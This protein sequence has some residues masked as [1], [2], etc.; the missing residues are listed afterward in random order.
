VYSDL[1][2][3]LR[4]GQVGFGTARHEEG[5]Q[6]TA[7]EPSDDGHAFAAYE[8]V[9]GKSTISI[10]R[11]QASKGPQMRLGSA[12]QL[13]VAGIQSPVA[14]S[15]CVVVVMPAGGGR[16]RRVAAGGHGAHQ[17]RFCRYRFCAIG[18]LKYRGAVG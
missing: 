2:C 12:G 4:I 18:E 11:S 6:R 10:Q 3:L 7:L 9:R 5:R 14:D 13:K 8:C 17:V 16:A 1:G 15:A